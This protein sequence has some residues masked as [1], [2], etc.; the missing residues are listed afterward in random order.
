MDKTRKRNL[1]ELSD[2]RTPSPLKNPAKTQKIN[3]GQSKMVCKISEL[4]SQ[5]LDM[6]DTDNSLVSADHTLQ[7]RVRYRPPSWVQRFRS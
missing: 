2:L 6:G 7:Y 3:L 5:D 4:Q 1:N